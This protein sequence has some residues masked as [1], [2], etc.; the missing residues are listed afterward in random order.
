LLGVTPR[1]F[2]RHRRHSGAGGYQRKKA[3]VLAAFLRY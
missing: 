2:R 3:A 1:P